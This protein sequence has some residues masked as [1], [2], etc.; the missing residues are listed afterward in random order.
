MALANL[1]FVLEFLCNPDALAK[2]PGI[3][4]MLHK[5]ARKITEPDFKEFYNHNKD[6]MSWILYSILCH[7]Q[8]II[9][10]H[11]LAVSDVHTLRYVESD[12]VPDPC[13]LALAN[14]QFEYIIYN[15]DLCISTNNPG[16][17]ASKPIGYVSK[18]KAEKDTNN[19]SFQKRDCQ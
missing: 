4:S 5:V 18:R 17:F 8:S 2:T 7:I 9:K 16:F 6:E 3:L 1:I 13:I 10:A 15:Y 11:A 14:I 12:G 19:N